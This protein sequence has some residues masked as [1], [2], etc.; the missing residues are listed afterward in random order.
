MSFDLK[1]AEMAELLRPSRS[2]KPTAWQKY[3]KTMLRWRCATELA[4]AVYPDVVSNV[5]TP[6]ELGD[7][8]YVQG[9]VTNI[10]KA[11]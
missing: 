10:R 8:D 7:A 2:G 5:Y 4:R 1:D 6:D 11:G 9:D 3:P